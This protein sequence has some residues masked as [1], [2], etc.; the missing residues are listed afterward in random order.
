MS[1]AHL[2]FLLLVSGLWAQTQSNPFDKPP[3]GVDEALRD[4]VTQFYQAH[5]DKKFRAAE[6]FVAEDTRDY[7]YETPKPAFLSFRIDR[8]TYS[9]NFTRAVV[10]MVCK[11]RLDKPIPGMAPDTVME[12]PL[13]DNWKLDHG[14]WFWF[15]DA[16]AGVETPFGTRKPGPGTSTGPAP[17]LPA[18]LPSVEDFQNAV[19][20]DKQEVILTSKQLST[21]EI[22]LE[23]SAPGVV[24]L[25]MHMQGAPPPGFKVVLDRN[26]LKP[27][28]R[29]R[30]TFTF[31]PRE[32]TGPVQTRLWVTVEPMN[33]VIP[34]SIDVR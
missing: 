15:V 25:L 17:A 30:L 18:T 20:A 8:I 6:A 24:K 19:K 3:A 31:T 23:N 10:E 29:A 34:I 2:P 26:E 12:L 5:V 4:R 14:A 27:G 13:K 33:Q 7:F 32:N 22:R 16:R 21:D 28:D 1:R 9:E 11:R